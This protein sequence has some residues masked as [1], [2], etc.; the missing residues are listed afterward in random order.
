MCFL[1]APRFE[2]KGRLQIKE[3]YYGN[4]C[5]AAYEGAGEAK[6]L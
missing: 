5:M 2:G 1:S 3:G 6:Q 4:V